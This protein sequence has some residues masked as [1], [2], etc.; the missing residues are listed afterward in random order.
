MMLLA[1]HS[2]RDGCAQIYLMNTDGT[3]QSRLTNDGANDEAPKWSP[4][5]SR[6]VFQSDRDFQ[7]NGDNP[8]YGSDIY[9]M[10][11]D[12]S[13]VSRLTSAAYDD[14]APVWSPDG[15]KIAFQSA[16]NGLNNQ[17]YVMNADGSG[18]VNISNNGANETQ[19]SWSPDG[20]KIAFASDRDQAGFSSTYV[21][22][23]NGTNQTRLTSS[24]TGFLDQQPAWSPDGTK[25]AFISTRDSAVIT[26][27]EWDSL[28]NL[29]VK[30]M[31]LI[32]KEVYVMNADGSSQVRLTNMMGNDDSP[33]WAPDG[34]KIVFRS[35][36]DRNCCDPY[37]QVWAMNADGSNQVNLSNNN[38]GDYCPS[39]SH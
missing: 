6:I 9:V 30:T 3:G 25:L 36:R 7:I 37:E 17:I 18:Q 20:S 32:N 22:S 12:G 21:M 13:G 34:T 19:P 27:D 24:G 2:N 33:A 38:S 5:N 28:G 10:N 1:P 8:I 29:V 15:T 16:R 39:W 26:W 31:L 35:D 4:D 11:W 23:A 14:I